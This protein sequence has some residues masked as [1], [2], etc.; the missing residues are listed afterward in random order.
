[1][2]GVNG[3]TFFYPDSITHNSTPPS[4]ILT[5]L[6]VLNERVVPGVPGSVLEKDIYLAKRLKLDYNQNDFTIC[7]AGLNYLDPQKNQYLYMLE[8]FDKK[9][10]KTASDPQAVYYQYQS[11]KIYFSC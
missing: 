5:A 11:G 10:I 7:F 4:V 8:G 9:W 3:Y 2:A 1:L 6:Y